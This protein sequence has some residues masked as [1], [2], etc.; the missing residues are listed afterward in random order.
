MNHTFVVY[1]STMGTY[2]WLIDRFDRFDIQDIY[3][4]HL[5]CS[6]NKQNIKKSLQYTVSNIK[7][8]FLFKFK[9]QEELKNPRMRYYLT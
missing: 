8:P 6:H 2:P 4:V 5:S 1:L 9:K 7:L 3:Q